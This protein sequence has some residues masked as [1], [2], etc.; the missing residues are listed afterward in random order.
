M[1]MTVCL[2]TDASAESS[3][4]G[5]STGTNAAWISESRIDQ[6]ADESWSASWWSIGDG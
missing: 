5:I 4:Y 6:P 2:S 3:G 1:D